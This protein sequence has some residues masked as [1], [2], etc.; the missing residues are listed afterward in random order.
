[1]LETLHQGTN[2][3]S[4]THNRELILGRESTRLSF[5]RQADAAIERVQSR[6]NA[7]EKVDFINEEEDPDQWLSDA[8]HIFEDTISKHT[9]SNEPSATDEDTLASKQA[10]HLRQLASEVEKFVEGKG[11]VEG[12]LFTEYV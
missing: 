4:H 5:R 9:D 11:D 1:M 6:M 3:A 7:G 8:E 10:T 12:A 2:F